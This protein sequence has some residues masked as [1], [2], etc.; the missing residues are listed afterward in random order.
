MALF[1]LHD[2]GTRIRSFGA[3]G[4]L[5]VRQLCSTRN[6]RA[7]LSI[8]EI[9]KEKELRRLVLIGALLVSNGQ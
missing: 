6:Y 9:V 7:N 2:D 3:T 8:V 4:Q 1:L 5:S